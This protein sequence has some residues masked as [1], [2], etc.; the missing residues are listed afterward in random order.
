MYNKI[1]K[2]IYKN[3]INILFFIIL[4]LIIISYIFY[5]NREYLCYILENVQ[6]DFQSFQYYEE[7]KTSMSLV[8][9]D[10]LKVNEIIKKEFKKGNIIYPKFRIYTKRKFI[11][12]PYAYTTLLFKDESYLPG[13]I[14][15]GYSVKQTHTDYNLIC[16]IQDKPY[17]DSP[18]VKKE[19]INELLNIYDVI[20]G[21]DYLEIPNY[22][23]HSKNFTYRY[24]N[25][26]QNI[27]S[28]V[29]KSNVFGLLDY[30]KIFFCDSSTILIKNIDFIF[31]YDFATYNYDKIINKTGLGLRGTFFLVMPS[32]FN[33]NKSLYLINNYHNIFKTYFFIRGVDEVIIFYTVYPN[34]NEEYLPNNF[35]CEII[36]TE[37]D[38]CSIIYYQ[39]NKPFKKKNDKYKRPEDYKYWDEIN[40]QLF[41]NY[42]KMKKYYSH[43]PSFRIPMIKNLYN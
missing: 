16:M 42:P 20:Y 30:E 22:I 18:G 1:Y 5:I 32:L 17:K 40:Q 36:K 11:K 4:I 9:N 24:K 33:Y 28:Y 3:K 41:I 14:T 43:I 25:H 7:T 29:T 13:I 31:N 12:K 15:F 38:I 34:W 2:K 27:S 35:D 8:K 21:V 26:Y 37:N 10:V 23:P 39:I 6:E 19:T